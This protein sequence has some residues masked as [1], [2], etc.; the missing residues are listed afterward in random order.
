[1]TGAFG[2]LR[3]LNQ[4]AAGG[5]SH[6]GKVHFGTLRASHVDGTAFLHRLLGLGFSLLPFFLLAFEE[7]PFLL[8]EVNR[9]HGFVVVPCVPIIV[10]ILRWGLR[11][12]LVHV[13][14]IIVVLRCGLRRGWHWRFN[15]CIIRLLKERLGFFR[16]G[17]N[18]E[19]VAVRLLGHLVN[20]LSE[21]VKQSHGDASVVKCQIATKH[22][23]TASTAWRGFSRRRRWFGR[24]FLL[25]RGC[26]R[27][28]GGWGG[29]LELFSQL[30]ERLGGLGQ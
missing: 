29:L 16:C 3:H 2:G 22:T 23:A 13:I 12:L 14:P 4:L 1:M 21:T 20:A 24:G 7:F 19:G 18:G 28:G 17:F 11:G 8:G 6:H 5:G 25:G 10:V 26:S 30:I 15:R 27:W 9:S